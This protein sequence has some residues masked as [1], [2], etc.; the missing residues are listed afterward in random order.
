MILLECTYLSR[1]DARSLAMCGEWKIGY[2]RSRNSRRGGECELSFKLKWSLYLRY[3][4]SENEANV[5]FQWFLR[6][7]S[8]RS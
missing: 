2:S 3:V 1:G 6:H 5:G 4:R 7:F 8:L